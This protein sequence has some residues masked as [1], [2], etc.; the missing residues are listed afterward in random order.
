M[1]RI[2]TPSSVKITPKI[3][4]WM[5]KTTRAEIW[6]GPG[7]SQK[8]RNRPAASSAPRQQKEPIRR[9]QQHE[10][11]VPP[12]VP[13]TAQVRGPSPLVRPQRDGNFRDARLNLCGFDDKLRGEFHPRA[14]QVHALVYRAREPAHPAVAVANAGAKEEIQQCGKAGISYVFVVPGHRF[15]PDLSLKPVAHY[16]VVALP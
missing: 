3:M 4:V 13:K 15:R 2:C 5:S 14:S 10:P 11:Q 1:E 6:R 12:A 16:H 8:T 7:S 9:I